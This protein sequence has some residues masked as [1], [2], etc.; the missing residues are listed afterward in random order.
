MGKM[1]LVMGGIRGE[2]V[3]SSLSAG[4]GVGVPL[5]SK[6]NEGTALK[7]GWWILRVVF[8]RDEHPS[9]LPLPACSAAD[10]GLS[11]VA[12]TVK[13]GD[14]VS[15]KTGPLFLEFGSKYEF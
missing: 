5:H 14:E 2:R 13:G 15:A 7:T 11:I 1:V 4:E 10:T 3:L 9:S 12:Q 6:P 8:S